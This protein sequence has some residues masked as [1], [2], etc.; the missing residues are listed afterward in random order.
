MDLYYN[1]KLESFSTSQSEDS[2]L[3]YTEH[4]TIN[5]HSY[6]ITTSDDKFKLIFDTKFGSEF[7]DFIRV[8]LYVQGTLLLPTSLYFSERK[9][10]NEQKPPFPED[11]K[12]ESY[13]FGILILIWDL[14][15]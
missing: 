11:P 14:I 7:Y 9:L 6:P 13:F 1:K 10:K 3:L 5:K 8:K 15:L 2:E 12:R 4:Y